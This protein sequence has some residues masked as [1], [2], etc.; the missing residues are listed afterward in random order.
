M[1]NNSY[2]VLLIDDEMSH[3]DL[4]RRSL[5]NSIEQFSIS[6]A[7]S[8]KEARKLL[9]NNTAD[10]IVVDYRLPDGLGI[11]LLQEGEG[12]IEAP[13]VIMTSYGDERI[14]VEAMRKGA[15]DYVV[16]SESSFIAMPNVIKRAIREWGHI[17]DKKIAQQRLKE[18]EERVRTFIE[19]AEDM[20]YF[21]GLDGSLS[22]LNRA[23]LRITGYSA[24]EFAQNPQLWQQIIHPE[25][26][27]TALTF[28]SK[29]PDGVASF[30]T[31]YRL[32][33]KE[34]KWRW[35]QSR[36]VGLK[37]DSGSYIGYNCIDRDITDRKQSEEAAIEINACLLNLGPDPIENIVKLTEKCGTIL[38]ADCASYNRMQN[39]LL[40]CW[41]AWRVSTNCETSLNP[42]GRLCTHV[43]LSDIESHHLYQNLQDSKFAATTPIINDMG[44]D[45][46]FGMAVRLDDRSVGS[47]CALFK[48]H[49]E[50]TERQI[51]QLNLLAAA[52]G[53]E[54][55][56]KQVLEEVRKSEERLEL[57]LESAGLGL[58][59]HYL[60][61]GV[62]YRSNR[63]AE[64]LG[65]T[66]QEIANQVNSW[67]DLIHPEDLGKS[68]KSAKEH[69]IGLTSV[70]KVE[71]RMRT[72]S[73]NYKWI[74][75]WGKIVERD[76]KGQPIR[77]TGTHMDIT[78]RK[79]AEEALRESEEKYR[80]IVENINVGIVVI[81][82]E[83]NIQSINAQMRN[84][85]PE[86]V[87]A[88]M[89]KCFKSM[90][91]QPNSGNCENCPVAQTMQDKHVHDSIID[92]LIKGEK[93]KLRVIASPITNKNGDLIAVIEL[94]ED[95]T[96]KLKLDDELV[97]AEKLE[98]VGVLAGGIAH[99]FNNI[100]T[101]M[102]GNISLARIEMEEGQDIR[103]LLKEVELATVRAKDL[104]H[105]LLTFSK[106]GAPIK[107]AASISDII[108]ESAGFAI[109]GSSVKLD[110]EFEE[111]LHSV[112]VDEGQISQV[113]SN[114]VINANQSM[115]QGGIIRIQCSNIEVTSES[116]LP[117]RDGKYIKV[118]ISDQGVGIPES[119]LKKIFD[120]FFTTKQ[121]GSGL[122]LAT[123]YSIIRS[124]LGHIDVSS[125]IDHGTSFSIYLPALH[126]VKNPTPDKQQLLEK[127]F[128]RVLIVD[129]ELPVL[130]LATMVLSKL[131]YQPI[132]A[133][134]GE[135][136]LKIYRRSLRD[137]DP[138]DVVILD[139]TIPGGMG[140]K[141]TIGELRKIDP[142]VTAIVSSGYANNP[143]MAQYAEYGF[144][145]RVAKPYRATELGDVVKKVLNVRSLEQE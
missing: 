78:D 129:D 106:G 2:H 98:S 118:L 121:S 21:K 5:A 120:P 47:L 134:D 29:Y 89:L 68:T 93:R 18:S 122:G 60:Q 119:H 94:L 111:D 65:Y 16:K 13:V 3:V 27:Q 66:P 31:E 7:S 4:I 82:T 126:Y 138:I 39:N 23:N 34:G 145:G 83:Y 81:D 62:V 36:M 56:R 38:G 12:T 71:H 49:F 103:Q 125:I 124:H 57:A 41:G 48:N 28:F 26:V 44:L 100:L 9:A 144:M 96:D 97:K 35:I 17:N 88:N 67:T 64:M 127:G 24:E 84:W 142:E 139:L 113:I 15:V 30:E 75:N 135:E 14:A 46:Y 53:L 101:S 128:G 105:Q 42:E 117:L 140:G 45:T 63:W 143:V 102:L 40:Q 22:L 50:P 87:R 43:I 59:D 115:P 104:T 58:W 69:E 77:A 95:I 79:N 137:K 11:E 123:T 116:E 108:K 10:V 99:D 114:L 33:S 51:G 90:H 55:K 61:D 8:L 37:D 76:D 112:E 86:M 133:I 70:Y 107:R 141:E 72:K 80:G 1:S 20:V 110:C 25:D 131:G 132:T 54:E 85:F 19:S 91:N 52:I 74:L 136:A 32:K 130:K 109:R 73:G 6:V 92:F